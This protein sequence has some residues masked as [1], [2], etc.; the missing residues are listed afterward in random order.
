ME[1]VVM[2]PMDYTFRMD[3]VNIL[4]V[5]FS[6]D[7]VTPSPQDKTNASSQDRLRCSIL[8]QKIKFIFKDKSIYV[9]G[10]FGREQEKADSVKYQWPPQQ[11]IMEVVDVSM[12][13]TSPLPYITINNR[14]LYKIYLFLVAIAMKYEG[15]HMIR[16]SSLAGFSID[17]IVESIKRGFFENYSNIVIENIYIPVV[18]LNKDERIPRY[19]SEE[20]DIQT[21][22]NFLLDRISKQQL[23]CKKKFASSKR[24]KGS[25]SVTLPQEKCSPTDIVE[26]FHLGSPIIP[27]VAKTSGAGSH[28]T[29]YEFRNRIPQ[30]PLFFDST[31]P[32]DYNAMLTQ[33]F[34][35]ISIQKF[36][37]RF[38]IASPPPATTADKKDFQKNKEL[39]KMLDANCICNHMP[40]PDANANTYLCNFN[41]KRNAGVGS[42]DSNPNRI[43]DLEEKENALFNTPTTDSGKGRG[44]RRTKKNKTKRKKRR[45]L[46]P[47]FKN[48]TYR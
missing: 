3:Y 19:L 9:I 38:C 24:V 47:H 20:P 6:Q 32:G 13:E 10:F 35:I 12:E 36:S 14:R 46:R 43:I 45:T 1:E 42:V 21:W 29:P 30:E 2:Q 40:F 8:S 7:N 25:S 22:S 44:K 27:Y 41:Y 31:G 4:N 18:I 26:P 34:N 39:Q 37:E 23:F 11:P 17:N 48:R 16:M 28:F 15:D 5:Y 33:L